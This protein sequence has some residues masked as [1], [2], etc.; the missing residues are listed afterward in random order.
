MDYIDSNIESI[1]E[2]KCPSLLPLFGYK[3]IRVN[4]NPFRYMNQAE[5]EQIAFNKCCSNFTALTLSL[6]CFFPIAWYEICDMHINAIFY[7]IAV[8]STILNLITGDNN[9]E[10]YTK[11]AFLV[12][13]CGICRNTISYNFYK[14]ENI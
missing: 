10:Y 12:S 3:E 7:I 9:F 1:I 8:T 13:D 4:P 2:N 14:S 5:K 11:Y 6:L